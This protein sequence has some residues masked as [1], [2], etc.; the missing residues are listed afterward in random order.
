MKPISLL[1]I[2]LI[3]LFVTAGEARRS[4]VELEGDDVHY[5]DSP[6]EGGAAECVPAQCMSDCERLHGADSTGYCTHDRKTCM[7]HILC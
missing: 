3:A 6:F 2:L 4:A 1:A 5:C 7:C